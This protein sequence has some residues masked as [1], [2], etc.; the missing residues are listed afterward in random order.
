[1]WPAAAAGD[2]PY[3]GPVVAV[4]D[5]G[6]DPLDEHGAPRATKAPPLPLRTAAKINESGDDGWCGGLTRG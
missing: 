1:V 6:S 2:F 5:Q 3:H 4:P